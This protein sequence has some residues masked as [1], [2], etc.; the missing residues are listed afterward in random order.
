MGMF[1]LP[2]SLYLLVLALLSMSGWNIPHF[3]IFKVIGYG[4]TGLLALELIVTKAHK[5]RQQ[6]FSVVGLVTAFL[7]LSFF[8]TV[9]FFFPTLEVFLLGVF[10]LYRALHFHVLSKVWKSVKMFRRFLLAIGRRDL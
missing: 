7:L 2:L 1:G 3:E 5:Y 8:V 4:A 6:V 10:K 9:D